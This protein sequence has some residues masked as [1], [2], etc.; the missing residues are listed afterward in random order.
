MIRYVI[1]LFFGSILDPILRE[2]HDMCMHLKKPV[3]TNNA[4]H[5]LL[6]SS[7]S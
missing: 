3:F 5:L 4:L 2:G 7:P 6:I 1:A